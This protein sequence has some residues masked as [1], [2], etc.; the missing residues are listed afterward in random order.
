MKKCYICFIALLF[1]V[2]LCSCDSTTKELNNICNDTTKKSDEI[3]T[4]ASEKYGEAVLSEKQIDGE[5][6]TAVLQ[7]KEYGFT[8]EIMLINQSE[9]FDGNKM[10]SKQNLSTSFAKEYGMYIR[11]EQAETFR[12][13]EN[14]YNC[15]IAWSDNYTGET[16]FPD[17]LAT[18]TI[19]P[20]IVTDIDALT[21]NLYDEIKVYDVR[22]FYN[23]TK[24]SIETEDE[25][26]GTFNFSNRKYERRKKKS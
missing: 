17:V 7:D 23:N 3:C 6:L 26:L 2:S 18:I 20:K 21:K 5:N 11:S 14:K 16:Y 10:Y 4:F 19:D 24:F 22:N 12:N 25:I 1:C 9:F 8:Y 15:T 13:L